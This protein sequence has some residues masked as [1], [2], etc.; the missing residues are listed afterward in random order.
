ML[1]KWLA[2]FLCKQTYVP[3][4]SMS[5]PPPPHEWPWVSVNPKSPPPD[6]NRPITMSLPRYFR[7]R[8][9]VKW[10]TEH[11]C[12]EL[13]ISN[14]PL[15]FTGFVISV[16]NIR[17]KNNKTW[18][19]TAL[20]II[21]RFPLGKQMHIFW[22]V[23]YYNSFMFSILKRYLLCKSMQIIVIVFWIAKT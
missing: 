17:P 3:K 13:P 18:Q 16:W 12:G 23:E 20:L 15:K 2:P 22:K 11:L 9:E 7:T 6:Y 19:Q 8:S 21:L 5:A 10:W 1:I 4:S 14:V